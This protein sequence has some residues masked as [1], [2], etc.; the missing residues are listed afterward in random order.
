MDQ[1][2]KHDLRIRHYVRYTDDFVIVSHNISYLHVVLKK[3][4]NFLT[5]FLKL[6]LHP[7]KIKIRKYT[8]GIDFLGYVLHPNFKVIRTKTRKRII[9]KIMARKNELKNKLISKKSFNQS[10]QSYFGVL[11]HANTYKLKNKILRLIKE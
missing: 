8:Q 1:F 11:S 5:L 4:E 10:L 9:Q 7:S 2:I 6:E 3:I